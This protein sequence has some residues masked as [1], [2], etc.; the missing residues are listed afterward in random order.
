MARWDHPM[1]VPESSCVCIPS[2]RPVAQ[3]F[4]LTKVPF[5]AL[6][7]SERDMAIETSLKCFPGHLF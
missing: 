7:N 6:F 3:F 2:L 4:F 1:L 5:S